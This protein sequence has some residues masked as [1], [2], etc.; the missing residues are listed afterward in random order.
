MIN[1]FIKLFS[2]K[3]LLV[4]SCCLLFPSLS[5]A[6][7]SMAMGEEHNI[8]VE[9]DG[10]VWTWGDNSSGQLGNGTIVPN[11]SPIKV[12]I[13][14]NATVV[15]AGGY[16]SLVLLDDGSVL[17][18]G[19]N[20]N[21]QLGDDSGVDQLS[22]VPVNGISGVTAIVAG[23][24]HSVALTSDG[25]VWAWGD[26]SN[27]QLGNGSGVDSPNPVQ[28]VSLSNITAITSGRWNTYALKNDGT[29]W[30]WGYNAHGPPVMSDDAFYVLPVRFSGTWDEAL[31]YGLEAKQ[32]VLPGNAEP[33]LMTA[34]NEYS[35]MLR[36]DGT[37]LEAGRDILEQGDSTGLYV[38]SQVQWT[39]SVTVT[40]GPSAVLDTNVMW[41][42][43]GGDW[44]QSGDTA[45]VPEGDHSIEFMATDFWQA[46]D[47]IPITTIRGD[48][49][50]ISASYTIL[51]GAFKVDVAPAEAE[52]GAKWRIDG[53]V[54]H[55]NGETVSGLAPGEHVVEH[56]ASEFW[57]T[58]EQENIVI[59]HNKLTTSKAEYI[60]KIGTVIVRLEPVEAVAAGGQWRVVGSSRW[61]SNKMAVVD[62]VPGSYQIEFSSVDGWKTPK[63]T[64]ITLTVSGMIL[65][66]SYS[67]TAVSVM[68]AATASVEQLMPTGNSVVATELV[69]SVGTLTGSATITTDVGAF[70]SGDVSGG[71]ASI[72]SVA[73]IDDSTINVGLLDAPSISIGGSVVSNISYVG[74]SNFHMVTANKG[75]KYLL[76]AEGKGTVQLSIYNQNGDLI[77]RASSD[78]NGDMLNMLWVSPANGTYYIKIKYTDSWV[79]GEVNF[80]IVS[81]SRFSDFDGND[82]ADILG[83]HIANGETSVLYMD[84]GALLSKISTDHQVALWNKGNWAV[85]HVGDFNGDGNTDIFW[86]ADNGKCVIWMMEGE[87]LGNGSGAVSEYVGALAPWRDAGV[88]DFDGDGKSD[89]LWRHKGTGQIAIWLMDGLNVKSNSGL[90]SKQV[91]NSSQW[92]VSGIG[93]FNGDGKSDILWRHSINGY[94]AI[95]LMNGLEH[96]VSSGLTSEYVSMASQW[97]V[98]AT[99]DFNADGRSDILW[100]R[101]DTGY[102]FIW[103]MDKLGVSKSSGYITSYIDKDEAWHLIGVADH[104]GD[105]K[106]DILWRNSENGRVFVWMMDGLH[107]VADDSS[108]SIELKGWEVIAR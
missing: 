98:V 102:L 35:V 24:Y 21:G 81:R 66:G 74:A 71:V 9:D 106:A 26:N 54:W 15:A 103:F 55:V 56:Q 65:I 7:V 31:S 38:P 52:A 72:E 67:P 94:T 48:A 51:Q 96:T 108:D 28:L 60:R 99:D 105:G 8:V 68:N 34:G 89:V 58:P 49:A 39:S 73:M 1:Y 32:V 40:L 79:V 46:P 6:V 29:V 77:K 85:R 2:L 62:L 3:K 44:H 107:P 11:N 4:L 53:G 18:W 63:N 33:V 90:V 12:Q 41:R 75:K 17:S 100:R 84:G 27:G 86:R 22:P 43:A 93:D 45:Y 25:L 61:Y 87:R 76:S 92:K 82:K 5:Q 37:V 91:A 95:W 23:T 57:V 69:I 10:S 30:L 97:K 16:H 104:S 101:E 70:E 88:G 83:R 13:P 47:S 64:D 50:V 20:R 80:S 42:V 36:P 59:Q 78:A 14:G 19:S